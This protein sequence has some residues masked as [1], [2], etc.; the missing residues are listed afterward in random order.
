MD[1]IISNR[2]KKPK[3]ISEGGNAFENVGTIHI[4][5]IQPTLMW[6]AHKT[7]ISEITSAGLGS[8]GKK[9]YS[10]DID[11]A[12]TP[13]SPEE[14]K[15]MI[16][17]LGNLLG[18]ENVRKVGSIIT[19]KVPI[20]GYDE[21]KDGRQPRTGFVQVDFMFGDVDWLKT[22]YHSPA[23]N[24]S[25]FKGAHRNRALAAVAMSVDRMESA[26]LDGLE[27]PL[28][29]VRWKWGG[30]GLLKV[31]RKSVKSKQG[32]WNKMQNDEILDGPITNKNEIA[33]IL[34]G[35]DGT[36]DMMNSFESVIEAVQLS[37]PP[38]VQN[39]IFSD[40]CL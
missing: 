16:E 29:T 36:P 9:E 13:K 1:E 12:I 39:Q 27:R 25:K 8:V 3:V 22:Y 2:R 37:F 21:S 24:E 20:K 32:T 4:S 5:E 10:G 6:L 7:G 28:S 40:L 18:A 14:L 11:T 15:A 30:N 23:E 38:E 35:E 26:E 34:F 33:H 31:N 19:T 17:T